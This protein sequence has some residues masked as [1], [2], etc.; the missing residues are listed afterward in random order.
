MMPKMEVEGGYP[1]QGGTQNQTVPI[2]ARASG[3]DYA[4][5]NKTITNCLPKK[6]TEEPEEPE[7]LLEH[8]FFRGL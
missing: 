3:V 1:G 7:Q 4:L 5:W 6:C 2:A 8:V